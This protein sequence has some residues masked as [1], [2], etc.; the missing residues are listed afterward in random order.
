MKSVV[1]SQKRRQEDE[2]QCGEEP[3]PPASQTHLHWHQQQEHLLPPATALCCC[4]TAVTVVV[5]A[6]AAKA[7]SELMWCNH[8][9]QSWAVVTT[10]LSV[11][12][13]MCDVIISIIK[14]TDAILIPGGCKYFNSKNLCLCYQIYSI[15]NIAAVTKLEKPELLNL[16]PTSNACLATNISWGKTPF[17][18]PTIILPS[19]NADAADSQSCCARYLKSVIGWVLRKPD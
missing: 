11:N 2:T 4:H 5:G 7:V 1:K 3:V 9:E 16:S 13:V 14:D 15:D 10:L 8:K 12:S 19:K 6:V 17:T 18:I